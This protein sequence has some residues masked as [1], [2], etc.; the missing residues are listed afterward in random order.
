MADSIHKLREMNEILCYPENRLKNSVSLLLEAAA[1]VGESATF[2]FIDEIGLSNLKLFTCEVKVG[3]LI[4]CK[5][6]GPNKK[7]AKAKAADQALETVKN[8]ADVSGTSPGPSQVLKPNAVIRFPVIKLV[9]TNQP[10]CVYVYVDPR[11]LQNSVNLVSNIFHF[12]NN[13]NN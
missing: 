4:K 2:N 7:A 9:Y 11:T 1:Q 12:H 5:G 10:C 13:N 6:T 8:R 3:R